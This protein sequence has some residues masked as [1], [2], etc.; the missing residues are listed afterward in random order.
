MNGT[1]FL[2]LNSG[3]CLHGTWSTGWSSF[4][5]NPRPKEQDWQLFEV[6]SKETFK[7]RESDPALAEKLSTSNLVVN[8]SLRLLSAQQSTRMR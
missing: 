2:D 4:L 8:V 5:P 6:L 7:K 3:E 1:A